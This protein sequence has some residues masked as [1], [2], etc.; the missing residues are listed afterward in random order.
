MMRLHNGS[1]RRFGLLLECSFSFYG[2]A[3]CEYALLHSTEMM[4]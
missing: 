2:I 3:S 1:E 4:N